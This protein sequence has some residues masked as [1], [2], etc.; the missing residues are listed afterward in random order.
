LTSIA[1]PEKLKLLTLRRDM[2]TISQADLL[3]FV[4]Q[5]AYVQ[6]DG[7]YTTPRSYGAYQLSAPRKS[8]K[9]WAF[10]NHPVRRAELNRQGKKRRFF[11]D[12][13][14]VVH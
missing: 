4:I 5:E 12:P 1:A 9:Q 10:G 3:Q 11:G 14:G 8:G 2:H 7:R 13:N 6:P